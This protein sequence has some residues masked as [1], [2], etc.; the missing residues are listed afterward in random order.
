MVIGVRTSRVVALWLVVALAAG[1][2][3]LTGANAAV[4]EWSDLPARSRLA[5]ST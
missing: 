5:T 4:A 1:T 3:T 2:L